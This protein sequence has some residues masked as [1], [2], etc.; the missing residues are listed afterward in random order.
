MND[1]GLE[2]KVHFP[3]TRDKNT[4]DL[5]MTSLPA[6]IVDIHSPA[7]LSDHDIVPGTLK[8]VIPPPPLRN[9]GEK[10]IVIRKAIMNL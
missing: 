5:I 9:L 10:S 3:S 6:Q 8:V 7:R 1:H 2:Q 4:L